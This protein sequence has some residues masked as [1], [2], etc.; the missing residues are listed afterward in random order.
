M[1]KTFRFLCEAGVDVNARTLF[2]A[3]LY[4]YY[5][6]KTGM[7]AT[8][9]EMCEWEIHP[10]NQADILFYYMQLLLKYGMKR[11]TQCDASWKGQQKSD[12]AT[13]C[14][15][16]G[17]FVPHDELSEDER[18]K[19][20]IREECFDESARCSKSVDSLQILCR[21]MIRN[22]LEKLSDV[23]LYNLVLQLPLP[24]IMK[25]FLV[26]NCSLKTPEADDLMDG[27]WP[28]EK[29]SVYESRWGDRSR[30]LSED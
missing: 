14:R 2:D 22:H 10:R 17:Y 3:S 24:T 9:L 1:P 4:V 26:F 11:K 28:F 20:D 25:E 6:H 12:A 8:V 23:N 16:G 13:L 7:P 30:R 29:S 27:E 18:L 19:C 5:R 21:R 15:A